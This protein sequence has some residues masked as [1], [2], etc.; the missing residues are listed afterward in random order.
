LSR[1]LQGWTFRA[2][3]DGDP[4]TRFLWVDKAKI[5]QEPTAAQTHFVESSREAAES[6]FKVRVFL[7]ISRSRDHH[8]KTL[9]VESRRI[10][11]VTVYRRWPLKVLAIVV[12]GLGALSARAVDGWTPTPFTITSVYVAQQNNFQY[13]V[14][15]IPASSGCPN[16]T[17]W[18]YINDSDL[19][20]P[21]YVAAILSAFSAGKLI[22]VNITTT[23]SG[24]CH[25][26]ELQ[27][28]G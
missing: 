25:I 6:L 1:L 15:G 9:F 18:A 21:G 10:D 17:T 4:P 11:A 5:P 27:V 28:W 16:S 19:G 20:S 13:R 3:L 7:R 8:M 12:L 23:A 14:Y 22:T 2:T 26:V 24:F